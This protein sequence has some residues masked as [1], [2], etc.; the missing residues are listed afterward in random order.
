[1]LVMGVPGNTGNI[2]DIVTNSLF[3]L[4]ASDSNDT[5][6]PTLQGYVRMRYCDN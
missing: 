3:I 5:P 4:R 1:M 6:D 2:D